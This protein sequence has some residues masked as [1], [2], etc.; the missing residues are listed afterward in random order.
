MK[1]SMGGGGGAMVCYRPGE[2]LYFCGQPSCVQ[3]VKD[4]VDTPNC[5]VCG[6]V[7]T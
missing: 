4:A 7:A 3:A 6:A 2:F 1:L 5:V